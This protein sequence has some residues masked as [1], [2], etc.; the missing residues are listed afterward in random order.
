MNAKL[1]KWSLSAV[2]LAAA[3]PALA[4]EP[5]ACKTPPP[6]AMV[7]DFDICVRG[8]DPVK[9]CLKF[10]LNA[11]VYDNAQGL[12]PPLGGIGA[13]YWRASP[14]LLGSPQ[15]LVYNVAVGAKGKPI[16]KRYFTQDNFKSFC[17]VAGT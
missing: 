7:R 14:A 15:G 16:A 4:A 11:R 1:V 10:R 6:A 12:L 5:P 8:A 9:G 17:Q 3:A 2:L 13:Q